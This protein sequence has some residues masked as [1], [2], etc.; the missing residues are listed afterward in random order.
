MSE[1]LRQLRAEK[2]FGFLGG[3]KVKVE[4]GYIEVRGAALG[5]RARV[6]VDA[7]EIALVR[8]PSSGTATTGQ[9]QLALMGQ[10]TELGHADLPLGKRKAA[11]QAAQWINDLLRSTR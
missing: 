6:P 10:G 4:D 11:E 2:S 7:V 5:A 3:C 1:A 9:M 8:R